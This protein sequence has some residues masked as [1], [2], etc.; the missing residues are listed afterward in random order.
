MRGLGVLGLEF[1][2]LRVQEHQQY[3]LVQAENPE[4]N[5]ALFSCCAGFGVSGSALE[6]ISTFLANL[7]PMQEYESIDFD[8]I[9]IRSDFDS[10]PIRRLLVV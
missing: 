9:P 10:I 1:R 5:K 4:L 7:V 6:R 8:R 2:E 3:E